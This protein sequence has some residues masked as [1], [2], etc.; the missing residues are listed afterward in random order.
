MRRPAT[1]LEQP[2]GRRLGQLQRWMQACVLAEGPVERVPLAAR[3]PQFIRP[4]R[5]LAP[6]ERLDI[7]RGMYEVRLL[8]ALRVDYPGLAH[9]LGANTFDE[10]A[11]LY[12]RANPS[13]SYTLNRLGDRLPGFVKKVAGLPRPGF[14]QDLARFELASTLVFDEEESQAAMPDSV[15]NLDPEAWERL[16]FRPIRALRLLELRYPVHRYLEAMCRD[17]TVPKI[18]PKKTWVIVYRRDYTLLHF[19]LTAPAFALFQA[20]AGGAPLGQAVRGMREKEVFGWFQRWF[21]ER[22]FEAVF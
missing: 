12:I 11:K 17:D 7:Y 10:L 8:E 9:F 3:A 2:S 18:R 4:S 13:R 1:R 6:L 14:V 16:C 21:S 22:L 19:S 15:N 20:L 5:T